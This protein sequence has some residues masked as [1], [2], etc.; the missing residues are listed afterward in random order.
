VN[1]TAIPPSELARSEIFGQSPPTTISGN[2]FA[3]GC[4][5]DLVT[6]VPLKRISPGKMVFLGAVFADG[7]KTSFP[8]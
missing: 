4:G 7:E 6:S 5:D 3:K 1:G 2:Y 8:L